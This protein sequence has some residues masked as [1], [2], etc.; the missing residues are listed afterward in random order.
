MVDPAAKN[1][2]YQKTLVESKLSEIDILHPNVLTLDYLSLNLMGT[3]EGHMYYAK[4]SDLVYKRFGYEMGNPW[5]NV[6][7]KTAFLDKNKEHKDGD[8]FE[9]SYE[10]NLATGVDKEN[11]KLVVERAPLFDVS[12]NGEILK[13]STETWL[14]PDFNCMDITEYVKT[15]NNKIKLAVNHFDNRCEIMPVYILGNF[16]LKSATKGWNIIPA[17]DLKIGSW[18]IQGLPFYSESAKYKKHIVAGTPG[19]YEIKLQKWNG[20]V[21]EVLVNGKSMGIIQSRP[22]TKMVKL[23]VGGNEVSVVIY[24]SL[25]NVFGPHHVIARGFMRPPAFRKGKEIM[26]PG[27]AY[28]VLDYGLMEDFEIH[29]L[30]KF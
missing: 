15:G 6:Q 19:D 13:S 14:D 28:D 4:A 25:K 22:H 21:V 12:L 8:R 11:M 17:K 2:K 18:K 1:A 16:S 9:I 27:K 20:T 10:F 29:R 26:P 30:N 5:K 3:N 7:Y 24:G 23:E